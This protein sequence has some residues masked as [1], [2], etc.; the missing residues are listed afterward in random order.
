MSFELILAA[1]LVILYVGFWAWHSQG[2]GKLTQAEIDEY[3]AIIE[4][5][6]V[7]DKGLQAFI[8]RLRPW[9]K[10]DDG[11]PIY[12][13]NLIHFFPKLQ[14][15]PGAPEFRGTPNRPTHTMK[16]ALCGCG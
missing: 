7:P 11:K 2:G 15:F 14:T 3:L 1:A 5:L 16:R 4:K 10:A 9:S 8:A 13:F 12:M 6:S